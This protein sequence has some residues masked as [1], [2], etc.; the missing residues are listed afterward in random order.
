MLTV[1]LVIPPL[2]SYYAAME[3]MRDRLALPLQI[4]CVFVLA[5][6]WL[7]LQRFVLYP[8][9]GLS[10]SIGESM[11]NF[12]LLPT[13]GIASWLAVRSFFYR[14]RLADALELQAQ[15]ELRL[16]ESQL[17]PHTLFNM[18]NT[19][20]SVLLTDHEKAVPLFLSMSEALRH[21]VDRTR[22]PWIP[23]HEEMD[24]IENYAAL[25]RARSPDLVSIAIRAEG[26]LG[27]P[28]P[29]MLLATLFDNA[30]THGRFP[31]GA[32]EIDV[33]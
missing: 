30:V 14:R 16:L 7:L 20:Y 10:I 17:A 1:L 31:D 29:P 24:F 26:D 13:F 9:A 23:L 22:K 6:V 27:V 15:T 28:V 8:L 19:V 32:L 11:A 5:L 3:M 21:V 18:L 12:I 2:A 25:E 4:S 33:A